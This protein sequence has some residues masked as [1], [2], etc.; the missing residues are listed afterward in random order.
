VKGDNRVYGKIAI[1]T[2]EER[3]P[4]ELFGLPEKIIHKD[5]EIVRVVYAVDGGRSVKEGKFVI[6]VRAVETR[7]FMTAKPS[8]IPLKVL[9]QIAEKVK[10]DKRVSLVCYDLTSKPP[11]TVEFE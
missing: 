7:D 11:A 9:K 1:V 3:G 2:G 8:P 4:S 6:I 10:K 5:K